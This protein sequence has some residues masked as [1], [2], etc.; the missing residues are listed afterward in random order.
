MS[1]QISMSASIREPA[2]SAE[3]AGMKSSPAEAIHGGGKSMDKN[4][5]KQHV[6]LLHI[7]ARSPINP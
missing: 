2:E 1:W 4:L 7:L 5:D 6:C 3:S